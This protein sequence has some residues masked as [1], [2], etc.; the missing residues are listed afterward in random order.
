MS[1]SLGKTTVTF[2]FYFSIW[3]NI[4]RENSSLTNL[5]ILGSSNQVWIWTRVLEA[6]KEGGSNGMQSFHLLAVR[7]TDIIKGLCFLFLK[8]NTNFY[9]TTT[10]FT[11]KQ[12]TDNNPFIF[13]QCLVHR[14]HQD[15]SGRWHPGKMSYNSSHKLCNSYPVHRS[16][17]NFGK[18]DAIALDH[19]YWVL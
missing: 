4:E 19:Y 5:C 10:N 12:R 7:K 16:A 3:N 18:Y 9:T 14:R 2:L 1:V 11:S 15:R 6:C 8:Q 17:G 13:L